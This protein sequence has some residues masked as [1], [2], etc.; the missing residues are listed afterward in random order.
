MKT[1]VFGF[2]CAAFITFM[3]SIL[4]GQL[5][6]DRKLLQACCDH[7][8]L[9]FIA[10]SSVVALTWFVLGTINHLKGRR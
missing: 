4:L 1:G 9:F 3:L 7:V 6:E 10:C 2:L 5:E 8:A